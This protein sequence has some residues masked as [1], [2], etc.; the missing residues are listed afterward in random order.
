MAIKRTKA[1][2]SKLSQLEALKEYFSEMK[3]TR[4]EA[5]DNKSEKWQEGEK[6]EEESNN[7]GELDDI[8]SDLESA[9]DKMSDL[10]TEDDE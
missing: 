1:I 8:V 3:E 6:G 5:F 9:Y 2:Q 4:Q 10:F 7:L